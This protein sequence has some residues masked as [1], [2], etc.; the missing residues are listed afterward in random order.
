MWAFET[1]GVKPGATLKECKSA[2][3]KAAMEHHPDRGGTHNAFLEI[4]RAWGILQ[5]MQK[6]SA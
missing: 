5:E 6:K 1:L 4:R 3:R 2:Y